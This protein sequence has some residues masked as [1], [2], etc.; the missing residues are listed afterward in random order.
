[1]VEPS[2]IT[3]RSAPGLPA[4]LV[5]RRAQLA[6]WAG[7]YALAIVYVSVVLGPNGVNFVPRDPLA[8]WHTLSATPYLNTGS[9]QR[10]DWMAN[11]LMLVPLGFLVAGALR[12]RRGRIRRGLAAVA[13]FCGCVGFIVAV[14]YAQL[15]FPPRTVSL[16]YI[17]AQSLG[18]LL[19]V[20]LFSLSHDRLI[21]LRQF[22]VY[23]GRRALTVACGLYALALFL[24]FL[25][26]FDL[27]LS[28]EDLRER[29]AVLPHLLAS[30]PGE[31]RPPGLRVIM[32]LMA[33]AATIP[34]GSFLTLAS[35]SRSL[36]RIAVIGCLIM[37]GVAAVSLLLVDATPSLAAIG[38]RTV[39]VVIGG[40]LVKQF[41]GQDPAR[42]RNLLAA[43]VPWLVPL[44]VLGLVFVNGLLTPHWRDPAEALAAF[45]DLGLLPFYHHYI[46]SKAHAAQSVAVE[47]VCFA[48]IGVMVALRR[49][50]G[51]ASVWGAAVA[52]FLFSLA[53]ELGRLFKPGLQPD[54]SNAIIAAIAAGL[55]ARLTPAFWRMLEGRPI[56]PT[57]VRAPVR[58]GGSKADRVS[59]HPAEAIYRD[60]RQTRPIAALARLGVALICFSLAG[61]ITADYPLAP[62]VLGAA[63][64]LYGA[65]L[66]RWPSLWLAVL[67]AVLPALDLTPWTGWMYAGEPDLFALVTIGILALR[68]PPR[69]ADFRVTGLP[70]AAL[71]LTL[72][73]CLLS[74][75]LGLAV[76]GPAGGSDNPYLRPDNAL[77]LAKGLVTALALLPFLRERLRTRGDAMIWLGG[78]MTAGLALVAAAALVERALFPGVFDFTSDYRVVATFSSMHLGG[79]Y[80]GA[81]IAMALP[82]L[83]VCVVR[84]RALSLLAM[85][86]VG[87]IAG[88][89]LLASF[90]R[91][92]YAS[93]LLST[94]VAC[95]GW[96]WSTRRHRGGARSSPVLSAMLLLTIG[97]IATAGLATP[98]MAERINRVIPDLADREANWTG[99]LALRGAG[100]A[101]ALFG[102]GLGTYPRIVLARKPGGRF[103]TNF[104]VAHDG[105]YGF[106]SLSA[107]TAIYFGQKV[108]IEPGQIYRLFLALRSPDGR[109]ALSIVLC[110]K[111]LLYSE[112]CRGLTLTPRAIGS[113][114]DFGAA[115]SAAGLDRRVLFGWLRRPVEL[116]LFDPVPGT[117]VDLGHIRMFDEHGRDVL[118]NGDFSHGKER[119]YFTDD[120]HRVWRIENQYLMTLF[121]S[122][123]LG[124]AAFILLCVT[125]LLGAGRAMARGESMAACFAASL[126]AVMFSSVFDCLLEV[127]RL[128]TLFYLVAFCG[129]TM[130]HAPACNKPKPDRQAAG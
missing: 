87:T 67:P 120:D 34:V 35:R 47:L 26:P 82:F 29:V 20:A 116:D 50:G 33:T 65:A 89:A 45:N 21:A 68:A 12:P 8:A 95:L 108:P 94:V 48:P 19:G 3:S 83:L 112:N 16:N 10:P 9:D 58:G 46:V 13:A 113:W 75:G 85:L 69:P 84:P 90:A 17:L 54:F 49:G 24:F 31:G 99:G 93:A 5:D 2:H 37:S 97:A 44:Y 27:A 76:P 119:W 102:T 117:I 57:E 109:G 41:E 101:T 11:L 96:A 121:E 62:R 71:A 81:Y 130:T 110:E 32:V 125:A 107:G 100:T 30:W 106:L 18:C 118:A 63:L 39:G 22:V 73:S 114:Q 98:Y 123:A 42:W 61:F 105:G 36:L 72:A 127:P 1:M 92:A 78:G 91:A 53:I 56:P 6:L 14:K 126:A 115:I 23:G 28:P 124:V 59:P 80:V 77:R 79:G 74:I 25:F 70:A 40:I 129:L 64:L 103:P 7:V 88:Y 60:G 66:W 86:A 43:L 122:G 52:A 38:Y 128:A 111:I 15:F 55:A 4:P 104:V 51:R